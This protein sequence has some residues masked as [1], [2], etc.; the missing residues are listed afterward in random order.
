[1][2]FDGNPIN[3][4]T[5]IKNFEINIERQLTEADSKLTYLIQQCTGRAREAIKN[6][7]I[8][9][10]KES[11]YIKAKEILHSRYGQKHVIAHA[12]INRLVNGPQIKTSD[13]TGLTELA[14]QMQSCQSTLSSM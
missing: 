12:Y 6:C 8:I 3:Y 1:M 9:P 5:F 10:D 7:I 4:W 13:A 14:S 11:A 2:T